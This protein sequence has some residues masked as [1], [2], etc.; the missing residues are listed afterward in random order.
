ME[1]HLHV[2]IV[3]RS[4]PITEEKRVQLLD[5]LNHSAFALQDAKASGNRIG[6]QQAE[7][8]YTNAQGAFASEFEPDGW[9]AHIGEQSFPIVDF[10]V[11]YDPEFRA[12]MLSLVLAPDSLS[13][14]EPPATPPQRPGKP[15]VSSWGDGKQPDP[16]ESIPG[17]QSESLGEQVASH[18]EQVALRTWEP[19]NGQERTSPFARLLNGGQAATA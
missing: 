3:P 16:R 12:P 11:Q 13:I 10:A 6:V 8:D 14:G 17:W 15:S 7:I 5:A 18:A 9:A 2:E 4:K 1:S 19:S